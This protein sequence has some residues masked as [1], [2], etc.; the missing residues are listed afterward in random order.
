MAHNT[1]LRPANDAWANILPSE[2]AALDALVASG[3]NADDGG[4]YAPLTPIVIGNGSP[5]GI[6]VDGPTVIARGG[7]VTTTS[8]PSAL[9]APT[10]QLLDGDW[11][12]LDPSN[13][14]RTSVIQIPFALACGLP[15]MAWN[16][17]LE[18]GAFQAYA[19]S[20]DASD[21]FGMRPARA[22][23][24][25][26]G[27]QGATLTKI[28][29][30]FRVGAK[31]VSLPTTMPSFRV[32]RIDQN[33]AAVAMTSKA[34]GADV[35]G[36]VFIPAPAGPDAW[37]N[38]FETQSFD[39]PVD[40]NNIMD[41]G[42]YDY[43]LEVVE[44]QGLT[45]YPW[46]LT[47]TLPVLVASAG[48]PVTSTC[49][50]IT[51]GTGDFFLAKDELLPQLNG[52]YVVTSTGVARWSGLAS[53]SQFVQGLVVPVAGAGVA[54]SFTFWQIASTITSWTP[55]DPTKLGSGTG[56]SFVTK[57]NAM[58]PAEGTAFFGHGILWQTAILSFDCPDLQPQ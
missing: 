47:F 28:T 40:Q 29:V 37:D 23:L 24:R 4:T 43:A 26:R 17:R 19:P 3:I 35:S 34:A 33:G 55:N 56:L 9:T 21:G 2:L 25:L 48:A 11:P 52:L 18:T 44:E 42:A 31:H 8:D 27:H 14:F 49:D 15:E 30:F 53:G 1:R 50:G 16:V 54:N 39:I 51:L 12:E 13:I 38:N 10:V 41:V 45:G 7:S 58:Y 6:V 20:F 5:A 32:L 22:Y 57:A 36:Y 46:E